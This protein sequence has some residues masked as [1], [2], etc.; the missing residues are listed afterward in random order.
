MYKIIFSKHLFPRERF[1]FFHFFSMNLNIPWLFRS[2]GSWWPV[3]TKTPWGLLSRRCR[4]WTSDRRTRS[5]A[6]ASFLACATSSH[7]L[8]VLLRQ[9]IDWWLFD[10][11]LQGQAGY[12]VY[13]YVPY[14]PVNEVLPYLSRWDNCSV[15]SSLF[16]CSVISCRRAREN[17]GILQ[18]LQKEKMLLRKELQSRVRQGQLLHKPRGDYDPI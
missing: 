1:Y 3:T 16:H 15:R 8:W 2:W 13:K 11:L 12:S 4:L 10:L 9:H 17:S 14:G 18:K 6:S 7:F 5:S